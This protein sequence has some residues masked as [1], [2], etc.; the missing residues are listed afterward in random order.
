MFGKLTVFKRLGGAF[1]S[2]VLTEAA[3]PVLSGFEKPS[4]F[5]F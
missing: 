1:D 4:V 5:V 2:R 3:A